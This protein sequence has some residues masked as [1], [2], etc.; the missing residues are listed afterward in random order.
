MVLCAPPPLFSWPRERERDKWQVVRPVDSG[1]MIYRYW[2]NGM[3]TDENE[4]NRSNP[5]RHRGV[6]GIH[7][8]DVT[9]RSAWD[10]CEF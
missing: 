9:G 6:C 2:I 5:E 1:T 7:S 3:K 8:T 10:M 4:T